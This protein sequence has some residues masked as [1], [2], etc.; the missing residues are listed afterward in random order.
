MQYAPCLASLC[1]MNN[2]VG[3]LNRKYFILFVG[4]ICESE[5]PG[6]QT[7]PAVMQPTVRTH[8]LC[9]V[10]LHSRRT[11]QL[12]LPPHC[13]VLATRLVWH[14]DQGRYVSTTS[15]QSSGHR[16]QP[17]GHLCTHSAAAAA[18]NMPSKVPLPSP[19][20]ELE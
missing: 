4:Y 19:T 11:L 12:L 15:S 20:S 2:C 8:S 7:L 17:H 13:G 9:V 14:A 1:R 5:G 16:R 10:C 3:E 18:V 6:W